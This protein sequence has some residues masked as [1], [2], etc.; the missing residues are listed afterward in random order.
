MKAISAFA[1]SL[2]VAFF[3]TSVHA[4]SCS[5]LHQ[6]CLDGCKNRQ[7]YAQ[8]FCTNTCGNAYIMSQSTGIF[9]T[10]RVEKACS[11]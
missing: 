8:G 7:G 1:I 10:A 3:A 4:E 2:T 6:R 9:K 5:V 11:R